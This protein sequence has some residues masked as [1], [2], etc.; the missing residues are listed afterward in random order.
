MSGTALTATQRLSGGN[1]GMPWEAR[2]SCNLC[3]ALQRGLYQ[4]EMYMEI[5]K[6]TQQSVGMEGDT[7]GGR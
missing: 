6:R 4:K 1:E 5:K 3:R 7:E 2:A